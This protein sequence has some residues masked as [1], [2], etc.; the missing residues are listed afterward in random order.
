[1]RVSVVFPAPEGEERIN[2]MPRWSVWS[3]DMERFGWIK[4]SKS[5]QGRGKCL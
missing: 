4:D 2:T 5:R 1:M 3:E